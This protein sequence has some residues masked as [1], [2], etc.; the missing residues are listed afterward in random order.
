MESV[1]AEWIAAC[2]NGGTGGSS[3][4]GHAGPL[5]QMVLLGNLAVRTGRAVT[6]NPATGEISGA[7]I[8]DEFLMPTYRAY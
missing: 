2:K 5:T 3:F 4:D 7:E 8:R 6:V 1:Y